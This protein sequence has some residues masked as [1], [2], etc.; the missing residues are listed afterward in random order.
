LATEKE[1]ALIP[2]LRGGGGPTADENEEYAR[3]YLEV[4]GPG[5]LF[6]SG[7]SKGV[8]SIKRELYPFYVVPVPNRGGHWIIDATKP[9]AISAFDSFDPTLL[10]AQ[11]G[12]L[13]SRRRTN[14]DFAGES[15]QTMFEHMSGALLD[16]ARLQNDYNRDLSSAISR[17]FLAK[18]YIVMVE[19]AKQVVGS[20]RATMRY[21]IRISEKITPTFTW[22]EAFESS[23]SI[24][25][26]VSF[27]VD[28][29]H[30]CGESVGLLEARVAEFEDHV[31]RSKA[32]LETEFEDFK[33]LKGREEADA[34]ERREAEG[35]KA[36]KNYKHLISKAEKQLKVFKEAS[37]ATQLEL[38]PVQ[39]VYDDMHQAA[40][41]LDE[42]MV[43]AKSAHDEAVQKEA[44]FRAKYTKLQEDQSN[45]QARSTKG[46]DSNSFP[47]D[48]PLDAEMAYLEHQ[49]ND[50]QSRQK[51]LE[52]EL[53]RL[54]ADRTKCSSEMEKFE[55]TYRPMK[56]K[57][58][59]AKASL[60]RCVEELETLNRQKNAEL[61]AS[62]ERYQGEIKRIKS[63]TEE[64]KGV[65]EHR[66]SSLDQSLEGL[67]SSLT[68]LKA[69]LVSAGK[70]AYEV[71]LPGLET[72]TIS[73]EDMSRELYYPFYLGTRQDS[74]SP[75]LVVGREWMETQDS[76]AGTREEHSYR[77]TA[78]D[79]YVQSRL[80]S[81]QCNN[82]ADDFNLFAQIE[83]KGRLLVGLK[84]LAVKGLIDESKMLKLAKEIA[85]INLKLP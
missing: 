66:T 30:R 25:R 38:M 20:C 23:A 47:E 77:Q 57:A 36:D 40:S 4:R 37:E 64:A 3:V 73:G 61:L 72:I 35:Q 2:F 76:S 56:A 45:L 79:S 43:G 1:D 50:Y 62:E 28:H 60:D 42:M 80:S 17:D 16:Y 48:A 5:K 41:K 34:T 74:P 85:V 9:I 32:A 39:S 63:E 54:S 59:E 18:D 22:N 58:D 69:T 15:S 33:V 14:L 8:E 7:P 49:A 81:I 52:E 84:E 68:S 70:Y 21:G 27:I 29:L 75:S 67:E 26:R 31:R 53:Q 65:L 46:K 83:F 19:A 12:Y 82:S 13:V 55:K 11:L 10:V 51:Q 24:E 78:I 71:M 44:E 6:S